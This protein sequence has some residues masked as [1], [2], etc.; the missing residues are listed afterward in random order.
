MI[1]G[2]GGF[3]ARAGLGRPVA[4][5]GISGL[6]STTFTATEDP[7]SEGAIWTNGGAVGLDWN[8]VKTANGR[9]YGS[10]NVSGYDDDIA[11]LK[12]SYIDF[13]ADQ[14]VEA[15]VYREVGYAPSTAK[16]EIELLVRFQITANNARGYEI[17]WGGG[18]GVNGECYIVRWN[19]VVT[20]YT[21]MA[22][23][24]FDPLVD[25]DVCRVEIS[26]NTI[27]VKVNGSTI[28]TDQINDFGGDVWTDGQ[29]GIGFWPKVDAN[30]DPS[31]YGWK[32]WTAGNL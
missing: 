2:A 14:Y 31:K 26:G 4:V 19:G 22:G 7:I 1:V 23:G 15:T 29:P 3:V 18:G 25:G 30:V 13:N 17:L 24:N 11:H 10:V 16:H 8:N 28:L 27:T 21:A 6:Y 20:S 12:T 9:A 32:D 5:G